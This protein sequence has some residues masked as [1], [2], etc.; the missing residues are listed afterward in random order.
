MRKNV[1]KSPLLFSKGLWSQT[2]HCVVAA[3]FIFK[4]VVSILSC[5]MSFLTSH[6][7]R[8]MKNSD[9]I[10]SVRQYNKSEL[11]RLRWTTELH[12]LFVE[13]VEH[14]GGKDSKFLWGGSILVQLVLFMSAEDYADSCCKQSAERFKQS[15]LK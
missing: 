12:D 14:L 10:G 15:F 8:K 3:A 9:R 2:Q 7:L 11:P 13:S 5:N 1:I 6:Q 4:V